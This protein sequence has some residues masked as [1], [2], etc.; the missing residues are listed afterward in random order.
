ML[1]VAEYGAIEVLYAVRA[2]RPSLSRGQDSLWIAL[3]SL[4]SQCYVLKPV[5]SLVR[6]QPERVIAGLLPKESNG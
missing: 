6:F 1:T 4:D 3:V 2:H 5:G